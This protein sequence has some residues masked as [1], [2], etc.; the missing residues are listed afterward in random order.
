MSEKTAKEIQDEILNGA[1]RLTLD[2]PLHFE[3]HPGV[4]C[5]GKCCRDINIFLTPYDVL[6]LKTALGISSE[7]FIAKYALSP[8][9]GQGGSQLPIVV[10]RMGDDETRSCQ[11]NKDGF[12][13]VY[14]DRPWACRMY[15]VGVASNQSKENPD[16][17]KFYFLVKDDLC[18]GHEETKT[19]TVGAYF[20]E[21]KIEKFETMN[22]EFQRIAS[23][24]MWIQ[25]EAI[26]AP[27]I[28]MSFTA[29][30]N[31]DMFRRFIVNSKF[32]EM[33]QIVPEIQKQILDSEETLLLFAFDWVKY[34]MWGEKTLQLDPNV[35][36]Q[37]SEYLRKQAEE[38]NKAGRP[39]QDGDAD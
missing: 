19:R 16:G 9:V 13:G 28:Q 37:R 3:C 11:F 5:F 38:H 35:M 32:F 2:D 14:E 39:P 8:E 18:K 10:L 24:P 30:Y 20:D 4:S 15:P 1:Q 25:E 34:F 27:K 26:P 17:E 31:L 22:E 21:Q 29:C 23:H 36:R 12:C 33:F 6:R 7:E